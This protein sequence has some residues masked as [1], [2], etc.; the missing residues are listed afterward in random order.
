MVPAT[1]VQ[2]VALQIR[3]GG[4]PVCRQAKPVDVFESH[5]AWSI[6]ILTSWNSTPQL[7]CRSCATKKQLGALLLTGLVGWWGFP[8]GLIITPVQIIRNIAGLCSGMPA[9]PS[10]RLMEIA[11]SVAAENYGVIREEPT[12]EPDPDKPWKKWR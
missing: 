8:F 12:A 1:I 7:S 10:K 11:E 2:E 4:C 9:Q 3:N 5:S 6:V